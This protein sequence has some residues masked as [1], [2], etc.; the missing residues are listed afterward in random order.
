VFSQSAA[1]RTIFLIISLIISIFLWH[2]AVILGAGSVTFTTI[3]LEEWSGLISLWLLY[4]AILAGP[5]YRVFPTL[6]F[7]T[8][9]RRSLAGFGWAACYFALVHGFVAFFG[10][11]HGFGGL[12]FLGPLYLF[13]LLCGAVPLLILLAMSATSFN[14]VIVRLGSRWKTIHRFVYLALAF[15]VAHLLLISAHFRDFTDPTVFIFILAF[16]FLL[17]LYAICIRNYFLETYPNVSSRLI[18]G[19]VSFTV[20]AMLYGISTLHEILIGGHIH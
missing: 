1:I 14:W 9:Y 6:P 18:T 15:L 8:Q 19:L 10:L 20:L 3:K 4:I 17:I 11:I 7:K 5:L 16:V 2:W 13:A 12:A